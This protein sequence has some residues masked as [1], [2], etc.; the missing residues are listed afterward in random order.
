MSINI[1]AETPD[2]S[3]NPISVEEFE[4][5]HPAMLGA[6]RKAVREEPART[7][8]GTVGDDRRSHLSSLDLRGI[9]IE[10]GRQLS[11]RDMTTEVMG[12]ILERINQAADRLSTE[13]QELRSELI[14]EH[15]ETVGGGCHGSI[16]RIESLGEEGKPLAQGSQ[17]PVSNVRTGISSELANAV[18]FPVSDDAAVPGATHESNRNG[19]RGASNASAASSNGGVSL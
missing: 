19:T 12:S 3:T 18:S 5:L 11:A 15:V 9:G 17:I 7:V 10:V 16:H 13:I 14:R 8:I 2:E 4:R 6:I 1:P